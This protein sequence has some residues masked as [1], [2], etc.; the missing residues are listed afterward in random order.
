LADCTE[1][2]LAVP[3]SWPASTSISILGSPYGAND[4]LAQI[5]HLANYVPIHDDSGAALTFTAAPSTIVTIS[6]AA[7]RRALTALRFV[8]LQAGTFAAPVDVT[9]DQTL[10]V[11]LKRA[12]G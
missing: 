6:S 1:V 7:F 5:P 3:S 11:I 10:Q 2:A 8:K 9:G 12:G 4:S